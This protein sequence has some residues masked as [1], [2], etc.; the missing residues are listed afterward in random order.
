MTELITEVLYKFSAYLLS[1]R[2]ETPKMT[3]LIRGFL[4]TNDTRKK[5]NI[6]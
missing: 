3:E 4:A 1:F 2:G 6:L 5:V